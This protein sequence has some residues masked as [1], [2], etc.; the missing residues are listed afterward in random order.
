M[1][2]TG[3]LGRALGPAFSNLGHEVIYG[4]RNP[5]RPE[6]QQLVRETGN[7]ASATGQSEAAAQ[8]Q[9]LIHI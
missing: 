1:I 7:G 9:S 5:T 3:D 4:S 8:A 2:G 6:I